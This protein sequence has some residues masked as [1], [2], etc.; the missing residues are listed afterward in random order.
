M[1]KT[2][3]SGNLNALAQGALR[4]FTQWPWIDHP[5]L[6]PQWREGNSLTGIHITRRRHSSQSCVEKQPKQKRL[7]Q[8]LKLNQSKGDLLKL[9]FG[10]DWWRDSNVIKL[11]VRLRPPKCD[12]KD[13]LQV[14]ATSFLHPLTLKQFKSEGNDYLQKTYHHW[15]KIDKR[16]LLQTRQKAYKRY[17]RVLQPLCTLWLPWK[18]K[19]NHGAMCFTNTEQN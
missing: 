12:K 6:K 15:E 10:H 11:E 5:S 14:W 1:F 17:D 4:R 2:N 3:F 19:Q 9:L 7:L 13:D 8:K 18:T 16:Q